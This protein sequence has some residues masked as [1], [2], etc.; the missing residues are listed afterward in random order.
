MTK[1]SLYLKWLG[2]VFVA[3]WVTSTSAMLDEETNAEE[4][5]SMTS[6]NRSL[7]THRDEVPF[8]LSVYEKNLE[9]SQNLTFSLEET[10]ELLKELATFDVG[11]FLLANRG[12]NG[13]W[14]SYLILHGAQKE[15]LCPLEKWILIQ[16]PWITATR[17]R[18]HIFQ[19]QLRQRLSGG[20]A[21]ASI[22]CGLLED[23]LTLE[24]SHREGVQL[25]GID[26]DPQS[27]KFVEEA[28]PALEKKNVT[29]MERN[30]WNLG[31]QEAYDIITSNGLNI[32]EPDN[33]K[34]VK[35]YKQFYEA[36]KPNGVLITSFLTPPPPHPESS[37]VNV[38]P[39]DLKKQKALF[40][41]I[42]QASFASFRT[43]LETRQQLEAAGFKIQEVIYDA[44][45]TFPTI[46]ARK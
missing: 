40:L 35:L 41:D 24:A 26:L 43:E 36:L 10:R 38:N 37:W 45:R 44:K 27:L 39:A 13:Y 31:V 19:D 3:A 9:A 1:K 20:M 21:V 6:L 12:L 23:L 15:N 34:V 7:L 32:Y 42:V 28:L 16:S 22:P 5:L 18:F 4:R 29:L 17:E 30:A 2:P 11:R 46:V 33:E 14:T 25:V 8:D